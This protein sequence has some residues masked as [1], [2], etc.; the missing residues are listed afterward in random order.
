MLNRM[1]TCSESIP[2]HF[3]SI[4]AYFESKIFVS[5]ILLSSITKINIKS[6]N[7]KLKDLYFRNNFTF[8]DHQEITLND[9]RVDRIHRTNLGKSRLAKVFTN[10]VNNC[11]GNSTIFRGYFIWLILKYIITH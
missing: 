7:Q 3:A 8:I 9:F 1:E 5:S 11:L 2:L 4:R 6:L 10:E